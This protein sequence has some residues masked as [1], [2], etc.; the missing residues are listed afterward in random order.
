MVN[1]YPAPSNRCRHSFK[2]NLR[3]CDDFLTFFTNKVSAIRSY[4]SL[5]TASDPSVPPMCSAVLEQF[6]FVSLSELSVVVHPLR[7]SHCPSDCLSPDLLKN[8]LNTVGSFIN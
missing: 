3:V 5:P 1:R 4:V 2:A 6:E 7:S 8:V